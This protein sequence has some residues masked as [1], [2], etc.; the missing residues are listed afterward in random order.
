MLSK[1]GPVNLENSKYERDEL[2]D[3]SLFE[4][5]RPLYSTFENSSAFEGPH[6]SMVNMDQ[7]AI[8]GAEITG[9]LRK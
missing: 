9:N 1:L 8:W 3:K 2:M 6:K 5:S 4:K 7:G